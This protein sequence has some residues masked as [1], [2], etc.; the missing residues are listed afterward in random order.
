MLETQLQLS[1]S[2]HEFLAGLLTAALSDKRV[3]V[4]RT[5][6]SSKMHDELQEEE[7]LIRRLIEKLGESQ[8]GHAPRG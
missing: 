5:E 1:P 4:R 7:A 3:E 8:V 6:F 2:E